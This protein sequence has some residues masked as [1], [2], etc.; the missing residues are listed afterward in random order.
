MKGLV[1]ILMPGRCQSGALNPFPAHPHQPARLL[2]FLVTNAGMPYTTGAA[3]IRCC[4]LHAPLLAVTPAATCT[5][6]LVPLCSA[7]LLVPAAL[8]LLPAS[9]APCC[10]GPA[11]HASSKAVLNLSMSLSV[12]SHKLA[13]AAGQPASRQVH[14]H[15]CSCSGTQ[16][17]TS[18]CNRG[19][20]GASLL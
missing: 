17:T 14:T 11:P 7:P 16:G 8:L 18:R 15:C 1:P 12:T 2:C 9:P 6:A 19:P 10:P 4:S 20:C 13:T 3:P 5:A